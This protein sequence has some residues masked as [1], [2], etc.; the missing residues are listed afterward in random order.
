[1][2]GLKHGLYVLRQF[3]CQACGTPF[4]SRKPTAAYCTLRCMTARGK[5]S[6]PATHA[7]LERVYGVTK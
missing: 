4:E 5:W 1:M 2:T 3:T 7:T 6:Y